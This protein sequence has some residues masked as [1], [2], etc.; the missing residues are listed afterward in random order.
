MALVAAPGVVGR[1]RA[2]GCPGRAEASFGDAVAPGMLSSPRAALQRWSPRWAVLAAVLAV[3]LGGSLGCGAPAGE[4]DAELIAPGEP[5][6]ELGYYVDG[7]YAP[8][9]E[10]GE[11]RVMWGTQGGTWTMPSVRM[12]GIASPALVSGTLVLAGGTGESEL[13]GRSEQEYQFELGAGGFLECRR[14]A[15]P[16]QHAPPRQFAAIRDVYGQTALLSLSASD[17]LGRRASLS[18]SLTLVED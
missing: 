14:V 1:R 12:W 5:G 18:H 10:T 16:V 11:A 2:A 9:S 15:V 3:A 8:V 6:I 13:L 7:A 4:A 17:A